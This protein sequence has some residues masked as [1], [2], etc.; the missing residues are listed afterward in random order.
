MSWTANYPRINKRD[1]QSI[2]QLNMLAGL[3]SWLL[4]AGC[5]LLAAGC[6][7]LAAGCWLLA[8]GDKFCQR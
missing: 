4:A 3:L 2:F 1:I 5:W 6:W 8:A 7:L